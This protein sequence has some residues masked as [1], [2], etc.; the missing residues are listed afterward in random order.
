MPVHEEIV[1]LLGLPECGEDSP[2][3]GRIED[4]LTDGYA[5]ALAL[6]GERLRIERRVAE[7]AR[8]ANAARRDELARELSDLSARLAIADRELV[9]LRILLGSL[10]DRA[11]AARRVRVSQR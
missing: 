1:E 4:T 9:R 5:R 7:I 8:E 6:D 10:N 2:S 11:R 3:L